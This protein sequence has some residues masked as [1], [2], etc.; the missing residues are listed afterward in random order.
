M[1]AYGADGILRQTTATQYTVNGIE[2]KR[3][4]TEYDNNGKIAGVVA[5]SIGSNGSYLD[6]L[7]IWYYEDGT[8]TK[9]THIYD[10]SGAI[11]NSNMEFY[12]ADG[13]LIS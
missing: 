1:Y 12:D 11:I 9:T 3:T 5:Y 13:N 8:S 7:S 4:I 2:A 6:A 10:D